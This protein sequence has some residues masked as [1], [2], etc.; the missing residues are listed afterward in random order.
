MLHTRLRLGFGKRK[1]LVLWKII[2]IELIVVFRHCV[3]VDLKQKLSNIIFSIVL[4]LPLNSVWLT[5]AAR[6]CGQAWISGESDD[7][8]KRSCLL[9]GCENLS[10]QE[11]YLV[12]HLVQNFVLNTDSF[13]LAIAWQDKHGLLL[14]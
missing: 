4:F 12:F 9:H 3:N 6:L 10:Y 8:E 1:V 7:S 11:Y 2:C 13:S 5:S 14:G